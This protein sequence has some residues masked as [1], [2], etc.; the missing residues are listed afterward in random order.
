MMNRT[1]MSLLLCL[2]FSQL[3]NGCSIT[4]STIVQKPETPR[5][6]MAR[7]DARTEGAIFNSAA[8]R[9][10]FEDRRPRYVGDI[11]TVRIAENTTANKASDNEQTKDGSTA[12]SVTGLF[13][14]NVPKAAFNA[15]S[16]LSFKDKAAADASNTFSGSV[17]ATTSTGAGGSRSGCAC[18]GSSSEMVGGGLPWVAQPARAASASTET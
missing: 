15:S 1:I 17:T 18:T 5:V 8:F 12:A 7:P 16:A 4:P 14:H 11:V 2:A 9:P 10:L 6:A 13:G 3:L